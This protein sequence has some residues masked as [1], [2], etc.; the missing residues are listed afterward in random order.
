MQID[1]FDTDTKYCSRC[2][3]EK[4]KTEFNKRKYSKDGLRSCCRLCSKK[5]NKEYYQVNKDKILESQKEY[6]ETNKDK[7]LE[8]QKQY[9]ETN[10]DNRLEYQKEYYETNKDRI[11][12]YLKEY[13]K[14]NRHLHNAWEAKRR[15][16]KLE[17]TPDWLTDEQLNEI[18]NIYWL[19]Q[20]LKKITGEDY[21]VDHIVPLQGEEVRGL[22]VP[23]NLQILPADINL[24]KG[25]RLE[26]GSTET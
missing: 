23:W 11:R 10:K 19:A 1:L 24:S 13:K 6:Y 7:R 18:K 9:Y 17:A 26:D 12:E 2:K 5:Y 22:H 3:Q 16:A 8:Y 21:H 25:N 15:A 20:D 4:S 14:V